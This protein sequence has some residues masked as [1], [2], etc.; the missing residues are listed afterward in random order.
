MRSL[1]AVAALAI[2][3]CGSRSTPRE[4]R[5][6][7][8]PTPPSTTTTAG[9]GSANAAAAPMAPP[10]AAPA[11]RELPVVATVVPVKPAD[12][13]A[14]LG[15]GHYRAWAHESKSHESS[16]PHGE[17]VKTFVSPSLYASL[18]KSGALHP[19][20]AAAVKELYDA[21]GKHT[22]WAVSVKVAADSASGKGWYWYEVLSTAP[23]AKPAYEGVGKELCRD[24]HTERSADQ[25]LVPFPLQ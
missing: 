16:G 12:L 15:A 10:G 19:E 22:G 18:Q 13:Q 8:T 20:G 17:A 14:W 21:A 1:L 7:G 25:V 4:E 9:A 3:A 5:G 23:G 6:A 2:V 24:C 11:P